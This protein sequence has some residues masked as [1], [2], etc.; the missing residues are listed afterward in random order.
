MN[1]VVVVAYLRQLQEASRSIGKAAPISHMCQ[2][3][4]PNNN[5]GRFRRLEEDPLPV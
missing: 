5:N 2:G 1:E 4:N 3:E